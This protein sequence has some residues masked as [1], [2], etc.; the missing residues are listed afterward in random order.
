MVQTDRYGGEDNEVVDG[1]NL[2][3]TDDEREHADE[4]MV[5]REKLW[6]EEDTNC[7]NFLHR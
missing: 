4:E 1:K 3:D 6:G 2:R 5:S 7:N